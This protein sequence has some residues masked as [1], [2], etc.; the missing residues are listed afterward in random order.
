MMGFEVPILFLLYFMVLSYCFCLSVD[1]ETGGY[2]TFIEVGDDNELLLA[3]PNGDRL[4]I[5]LFRRFVVLEQTGKL[6][7]K[8]H[9]VYIKKAQ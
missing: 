7:N 1:L 3:H 6:L 4:E 2:S 5:Q 8:D 9:Y